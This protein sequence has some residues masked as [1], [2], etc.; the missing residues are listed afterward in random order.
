[1]EEVVDEGVAVAQIVQREVHADGLE[2]EGGEDANKLLIDGES[3]GAEADH[4]D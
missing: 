2:G 1:M 3:A 4:D